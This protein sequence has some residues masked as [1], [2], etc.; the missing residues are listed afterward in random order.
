[1]GERYGTGCPSAV[2]R[3]ALAQGGVRPRSTNRAPV[4]MF[5]LRPNSSVENAVRRCR[6]LLA[7]AAACGA[8]GGCEA[9]PPYAGSLQSYGA[10][11]RPYAAPAYPPGYGVAPGYR[12]EYGRPEYRQREYRE[13]EYDEREYRE[14]EDDRSDPEERDYPPYG[15]PPT[16]RPEYGQREDG[17]SAPPPYGSPP[18]YRPDYAP[19]E[20]REPGPWGAPYERRGDDRPDLGP[21]TWR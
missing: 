7:L 10:P 3:R 14:R 6:V 12:S 9:M 17:R 4:R 16:Y 2:R 19:P 1:M 13:R 18:A 8:L 21:R 5:L 11:Y 20:Y 15:G